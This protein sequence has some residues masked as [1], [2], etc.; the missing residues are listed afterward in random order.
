MIID[1]DQ[2]MLFLEKAI[3]AS[4]GYEVFAESDSTKALAEIKQQKPQLIL[5]DIAMPEINGIELAQKIR[6][7]KELNKVHIFGIT[8]TPLINEHNKGNFEKII[9]KPFH[10]KDLLKEIDTFFNNKTKV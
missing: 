10:M 6:A 7:D 1:D 2:S 3:F 8:G 4:D 5:L 9:M